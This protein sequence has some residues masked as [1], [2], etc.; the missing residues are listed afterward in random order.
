MA[1]Q[2]SYVPAALLDNRARKAKK[3]IGLTK[4][5]RA[6]VEAL[7]WGVGDEVATLEKAAEA[8]G[9]SVRAFRDALG[10]PIVLQYYKEQMKSLREGHRARN[11]H[12]AVEI[13]DD[14]SLK[15]T[16]AGQRVRLAAAALLDADLHQGSG[17]GVNVSVGVNVVTPGYV[18]DLTEPVQVTAQPAKPVRQITHL[19]EYD[20][21]AMISL[22]DV[23]E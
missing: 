19:G 11:L 7:V 21:N 2:V 22:E 18:I 4:R 6:A 17:S 9:I 13:R 14:A 20:D 23:Q 3:R 12:T 5:I 16:A 10:K 8:G 15:E 1:Q